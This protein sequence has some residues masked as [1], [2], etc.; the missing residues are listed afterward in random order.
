MHHGTLFH[1]CLTTSHEGEPKCTNRLLT[2]DNSGLLF[3]CSRFL[4]GTVYEKRFC[5]GLVLV[6]NSHVADI[7]SIFVT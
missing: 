7:R 3:S 6:F 4:S 1:V 5:F 2:I